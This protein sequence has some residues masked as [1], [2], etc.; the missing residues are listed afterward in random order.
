MLSE[1]HGNVPEL[2]PKFGVG[3]LVFFWGG[4]VG[5]GCLAPGGPGG[6]AVAWWGWPCVS[7]VVFDVLLC[8]LTKCFF[9]SLFLLLFCLLS[10]PARWVLP[11]SFLASLASCCFLSVWFALHRRAAVFGP[12]FSVRVPT[13]W[14][15]VLAKQEG[16]LKL[17]ALLGFSILRFFCLLQ[18][19]LVWFA[20]HRRAAVF[21]PVFSVRVPTSWEC[22]LAKQEGSLKLCALLGFSILRFFCLLPLFLVWFAVHRTASVFTA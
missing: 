18:L 10:S 22:V 5:G 17:C 1:F 6:G 16:S 20:V 8:I 3:R 21:G 19:F 11:A 13:S 12:V 2:M 14:E 9:Q 15:C 4:V 7:C